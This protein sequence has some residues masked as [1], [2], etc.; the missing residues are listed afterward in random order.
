[1]L[2]AWDDS[3]DTAYDPREGAHVA[4]DVRPDAGVANLDDDLAAV[5][6]ARGMDLGDRG[7]GEWRAVE[8]RED[9]GDRTCEC[10]LDFGDGDFSREG[11]NMIL[12]GLQG[13]DV[14]VRQ[15]IAPQAERLAEFDEGR[16]EP[17]ENEG[18]LVGS[19][20]L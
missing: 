10:A 14:V 2:E 16:S 7:G 19:G 17:D 6:E 5:L 18:E 15:Q 20:S 1:M 4:I 12:Q 9:L 3:Y 13:G 11:S 8:V